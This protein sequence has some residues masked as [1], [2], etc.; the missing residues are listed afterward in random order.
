MGQKETQKY[1]NL[2]ILFLVLVGLGLRVWGSSWGLP[3]LYHPDE[4]KIV[5]HALAF[6]SGDLNPHYFGWPSLQMYVLFLMYGVYFVSGWLLGQFASPQEFLVAFAVDPSTFYLLGRW[7]SALLGA[8][9][10]WLTYVAGRRLYGRD[11]GLIAAVF[12]GVNYLHVKDS[13]YITPD[14][15]VAFMVLAAFYFTVRII[16]DPS[17]KNYLAAG[18]LAG[19]AISV[20]YPAFVVAFSVF[21]AHLIA[22]RTN[23]VKLLS[24]RAWLA[25]AL[26]PLGFWIGTPYSLL[27]WNN[28]L[29]DLQHQ[30]IQVSRP[31]PMI[32]R[33]ET[34][35]FLNPLQ[36][37]GPGLYV[38]F[39]AGTLLCVLRRTSPDILLVSFPIAYVAFLLA[40]GGL[41]YRYLMPALPFFCLL[42]AVFLSR[43]TGALKGRFLSRAW[44]HTFTVAATLT[45]A[46]LPAYRAVALDLS[47]ARPD[48]RTLAKEWVEQNVPGEAHIAVESY[49]PSLISSPRAVPSRE[50][51]SISV[52]DWLQHR[53]KITEKSIYG[54]L[55]DSRL[56]RDW[57]AYNSLID[58]ASESA[59]QGRPRYRIFRLRP[60]PYVWQLRLETGQLREGDVKAYPEFK[61]F[62]E[63][64][65]FLCENNIDYVVL[66]SGADTGRKMESIIERQGDLLHRV[67]TSATGWL[68]DLPFYSFH[69]PAIEIFKLRS[70]CRS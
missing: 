45:F 65:Q 7:L 2:G 69:N 33:L 36:A 64:A 66:S 63:P 25:A 48:T 13:H 46:F 17:R 28:F 39:V 44:A 41:Q 34:T 30:Q 18:I 12:L 42:A 24:A 62:F 70:R 15:P 9:T 43:A 47:L 21:A 67:E 49:G 40:T 29:I 11:V 6:G 53:N 26:I 27:D 32:E 4:D 23:S 55:K 59:Q 56:G 38:C 37:L 60:I 16:Q 61:H 52:E 14:V 51:T 8:L 35:L 31:L 50:D 19:L 22:V 58:G 10:I 57:K 3:D 5:N 68:G 54:K 1:L 20:K